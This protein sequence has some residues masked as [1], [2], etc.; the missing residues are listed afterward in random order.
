MLA[1]EMS[2]QLFGDWSLMVFLVVVVAGAAVV[3]VASGH[4]CSW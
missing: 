3:D 2:A 4:G 1:F